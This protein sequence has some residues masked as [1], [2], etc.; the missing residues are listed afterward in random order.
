[1]VYMLTKKR[2]ICYY[3]KG[4]DNLYKIGIKAL[5]A[6]GT[7]HWRYKTLPESETFVS[8]AALAAAWA[9]ETDSEVFSVRR[10]GKKNDTINEA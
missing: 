8:A 6:C 10:I 1:M 2:F 4:G 9:L 7:V 3:M 5:T